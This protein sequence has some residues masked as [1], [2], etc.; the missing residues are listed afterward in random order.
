MSKG[1]RLLDTAVIRRGGREPGCTS[2]NTCSFL[3][4]DVRP[5][6]TATYRSYCL[7]S[8]ILEKLHSP[9]GDVVV[10]P[11]EPTCMVRDTKEAVDPHGCVARSRQRHLNRVRSQ[12]L[13]VRTLQLIL[14][15]S[16]AGLRADVV[17]SD[18]LT[19]WQA[20]RDH[21]RFAD[22]A[23][24]AAGVHCWAVSAQAAVRRSRHERHHQRLNTFGKTVQDN[25]PNQL[26]L[27]G[28]PVS[29]GF[30]RGQSGLSRPRRRRA[31]ARFRA[32][33][34]RAG[35]QAWFGGLGKGGGVGRGLV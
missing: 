16:Q 3:S 34:G 4:V 15:G 33:R 23:C 8:R 7:F 28:L 11:H 13:R 14:E 22:V 9:L 20:V 26:T 25:P 35:L 29:I 6:V 19:G 18:F 21:V 5:A 27:N 31:L 12:F 24:E 32:D 1:S 30:L 2:G 17:S 10:N